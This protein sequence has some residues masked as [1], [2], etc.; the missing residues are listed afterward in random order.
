MGRDRRDGIKTGGEI[1]DMSETYSMSSFDWMVI[2]LIIIYITG[3]FLASQATKL[4]GSR[5][6][7]KLSG[8]KSIGNMGGRGSSM[9]RGSR[10]GGRGSSMARG[11][12]MVNMGIAEEA[13]DENNEEFEDNNQP[14][15]P[16]VIP[17]VDEQPANDRQTV[18]WSDKPVDDQSTD[19]QPKDDQP[20]DDQPAE[21][22][23]NQDE[24]EAEDSKK[25][26]TRKKAMMKK[27][28][29]RLSKSPKSYRDKDGKS[30]DPRVSSAI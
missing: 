13:E 30:K 26:D 17:E 10:Y 9:A 24:Q 8:R 14:G 28:K 19:D 18:K 16:E 12:F 27:M 22:S 21:I 4:T 1:A 6:L 20:E 2:S 23:D 29:E 15:L 7:R 5:Q 3:E 11:S 25:K